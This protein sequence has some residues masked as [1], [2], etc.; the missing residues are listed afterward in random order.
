M[1]HLT[2]LLLTT[3]VFEVSLFSRALAFDLKN[4][5][6]ELESKNKYY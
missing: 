1:V 2:Y 5:P 4:N 3:W 6:G